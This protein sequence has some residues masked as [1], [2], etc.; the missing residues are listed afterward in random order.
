M[1]R[2]FGGIGFSSLF[3]LGKALG[4][5]VKEEIVQ[6][7]STSMNSLRTKQMDD[8]VAGFIKSKEMLLLQQRWHREKFYTAL[9]VIA[10][11]KNYT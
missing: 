6:A 8:R 2:G 3:P 5:K 4:A 9:E 11:N 10:T 1:L 7:P